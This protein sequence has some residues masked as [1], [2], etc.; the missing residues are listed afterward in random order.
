MEIRNLL[1]IIFRIFGLYSVINLAFTFLPHQFTYILSAKLL[2][3]FDVENGMIQT[4]IYIGIILALIILIF[5]LLVI[6]PD[7]MINKI[8]PQSFLEEKISFEKLN[9]E[10]LL[11]IAILSIGILVLF[12]AIPD[13]ANKLFILTKL[14]N[15][16]EQLEN[17]ITTLSIKS[18]ITAAAVKILFGLVFIIFQYQIGKMLYRQNMGN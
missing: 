7:L 11:Q 4:W 14:N 17:S 18:E 8:R 9:P 10:T 15:M 16:N 12:E 6:N 1:R 3:P 2:F 5:C 13:L